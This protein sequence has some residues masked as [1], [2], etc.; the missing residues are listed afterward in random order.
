MIGTIVYIFKHK[1]DAI[2]NILQL[3]FSV[4][5]I[6]MIMI[7][8]EVCNGLKKQNTRIFGILETALST[9]ADVKR[10][11]IAIFGIRA[12]W[13]VWLPA[14]YKSL[15]LLNASTGVSNWM[16]KIQDYYGFYINARN[17]MFNIQPDTLIGAVCWTFS[18]D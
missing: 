18:P 11:L 13:N 9:H 2:N 3:F 5:N 17:N 14:V 12:A 16:M 6:I 10:K 8:Q 15:N 7:F 1:N 4:I